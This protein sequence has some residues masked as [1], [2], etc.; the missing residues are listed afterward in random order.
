M[1]EERIFEII[2]RVL[3]GTASLLDHQE[4][5]EWKAAS[6]GNER[7][8]LILK[9][10][11]DQK[12]SRKLTETERRRIARLKEYAMMAGKHQ[13]PKVKK[14]IIYRKV[15]AYAA[16]GIILTVSGFFAGLLWSDISREVKISEVVV[17]RGSRAQIKLPD[18][19]I[20]WLGHDSRLSYPEKFDGSTR[21]VS[22]LGEAYFDVES[23][24]SHPFL[25]HT[26][27][28]TIRVTGT[29][30]YVHD[31]PEDNFI[32]TSL[33]KGKVT[34]VINNR[35]LAQMKAGSKLAYSRQNGTLIPEKFEAEYYEFWKKGEYTFIDQP[36]A[37]IA[38]MMKRIYNVE[39][40]FTDS[41]IKEK[42]FTG[43]L[44]SDDNVYTLLEIFRRSSSTPFTYSMDNNT[45]YISSKHGKQKE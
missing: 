14:S 9:N 37:E 1:T 4:L 36:F 23:D 44:G 42:R 19:S 45:I 15:L 10:V 8:Y 31:Y 7:I 12:D 25:V 33:I 38:L 28:P 40:V 3:N 30:F 39:I 41:R 35:E 22:L 6:E 43:S 17:S 21:E 5:N 2:A 20:V 27:G 16:V 26:S 29:E 34:L 13:Q 11:W 32:E 24:V 18:G